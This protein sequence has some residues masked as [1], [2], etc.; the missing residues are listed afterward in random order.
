MAK[1]D[2]VFFERIHF[3]LTWIQSWN[4]MAKS[5]WSY[6]C[7]KPFSTN[8]LNFLCIINLPFVLWC[9]SGDLKNLFVWY[10]NPLFGSVIQFCLF[11]SSQAHFYTYDILN[12]L[13]ISIQW[14][15]EYRTSLAFEWSK[16]VRFSNGELNDILF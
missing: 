1:S 9:H 10:S 2:Y 3:I 13:C 7:F 12:D 4:E 8:S 6:W 15:S 16:V 14:G 5:S 11:F